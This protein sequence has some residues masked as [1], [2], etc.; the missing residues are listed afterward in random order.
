MCCI[1]VWLDGVPL[2]EQTDC[3]EGTP[4]RVARGD[5]VFHRGAGSW[6]A[7]QGGDRIPDCWEHV[8][9]LVIEP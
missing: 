3:G 1:P 5:D 8:Q 7:P 2:G 9:Q 6:L 4:Q